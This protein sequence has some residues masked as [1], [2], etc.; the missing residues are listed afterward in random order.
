M[1]IRRKRKK[2]FRNFFSSI[3]FWNLFNV[4]NYLS[5][6]IRQS[7]KCW[8]NFIHLGTFGRCSNQSK[9][10]RFPNVYHHMCIG[11]YVKNSCSECGQSPAMG[12]CVTGHC[13]SAQLT[14]VSDQAQFPSK[15]ILEKAFPINRFAY[16]HFTITWK[17]RCIHKCTATN[18]QHRTMVI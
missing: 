1:K 11:W 9:W 2:N 14:S 12:W 5:R 13:W 7:T 18:S 6:K 15:A 4:N 10:W 8:C 3:F 17:C 16:R